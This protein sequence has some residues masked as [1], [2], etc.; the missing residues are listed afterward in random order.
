MDSGSASGTCSTSV[1]SVVSGGTSSFTT[2]SVV[3]DSISFSL[4]PHFLANII[5]LSSID[6]NNDS[7]PSLPCW[8]NLPITSLRRLSINNCM[9]D[10]SV[11]IPNAIWIAFSIHVE[12]TNKSIR[13][14][15]D[16]NAIIRLTI[17]DDVE[18][19]HAYS[20]AVWPSSCRLGSTLGQLTNAFIAFKLPDFT[21]A[22]KH[23]GLFNILS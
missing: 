3:I 2:L 5:L 14:K 21:A 19:V 1:T 13:S 20:I 11:G 9:I 4:L 12:S 16:S 6:S 15:P 10:V 17:D 23:D 22:C 8:I 7:K 18:I